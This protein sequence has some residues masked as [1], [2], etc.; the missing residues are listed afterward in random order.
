MGFGSPGK[1]KTRVLKL[2]D[3]RRLTGPNL[4][5]DGPGA[6][7]EV[8]LEGENP[9][10]L[11]EAWQTQARSI[12]EAVG[13]SQ[14]QLAHRLHQGGLTLAFTAPIDALYAATEVNEWAL[15]ATQNALGGEEAETVEAAAIRLRAEIQA[16]SNPA[17]VALIQAAALH[18]VTCISDDDQ[19]SL[20]LGAGSMTWPA[21]QL[22]SPDE[23]DWQRLRDIPVALITGTNGKSTTVRLLASI[24]AAAGKEAGLCSTDWIRVGAETVDRGDYSGPGG[25]RQV[26]RHPGVEVALLETARGGMLRRGLAVER[27]DVA[28]VTNIAED[29]LGESGIYDLDE[30]AQAKLIVHKVA[31]HLVLNADDPVLSR[32]GLE[33]RQ[34]T[35]WFSWEADNPLVERH[36]AKGGQSC[37]VIGPQIV[38]DHGMDTKAVITLDSIPITLKGAARHNVANALAA[39]G[40]AVALGLPME[41]I[42]T[43]LRSFESNPQENPGRLNLFALGG[44]MAIVDFA[45]NPH[46]VAAL[47]EMAAVMKPRRTLVTTGQAGDRDNESIRKL[48]TVIAEAQ[49]DKVIVKELEEYLRGRSPGEV[50]AIIIDELKKTGLPDDAIGRADSEMDAIRRALAWAEKGDLLLLIAHSKRSG[51]VSYMENLQ[52]KGWSPGDPVPGARPGG[53]Y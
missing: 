29:H 27:A 13:W 3:S 15:A 40:V 2:A 36:R 30:L 32:H 18:E 48:A 52:T 41:S 25:A 24:V 38:F 34:P 42:R 28:L 53:I 45:H 1:P 4:L 7:V 51:I 5:L 17:Q 26:L 35:T 49:P 20:G 39:V 10:T 6:V 8:E 12:L 50:P 23:V 43:G 19:I 31:G 14:S 33:L 44:A 21:R 47:L 37:R 9:D 16:E 46:G 22:P 11:I